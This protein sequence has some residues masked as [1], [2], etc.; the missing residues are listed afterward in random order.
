MKH[1][2]APLLDSRLF[3]GLLIGPHRRESLIRRDGTEDREW[4]GAPRRSLTPEPKSNP[5]SI[6]STRPC[7][8]LL[9][10]AARTRPLRTAR[11]PE[12]QQPWVGHWTSSSPAPPARNEHGSVTH[13]VPER[14][15]SEL[16]CGQQQDICSGCTHR[17]SLMC[18]VLSA[19]QSES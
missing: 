3:F 8:L 7:T 11:R 17:R 15:A 19:F 12:L 14:A 4:G 16:R 13:D 6:I 18:V 2:P 10:Q 5:L 1:A 9:C